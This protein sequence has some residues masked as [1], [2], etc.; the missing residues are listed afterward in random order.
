[1][2]KKKKICPKAG[3]ALKREEIQCSPL[4]VS[5]RSTN[6]CLK[7]DLTQ[8]MPGKDHSNWQAILGH[9]N[10]NRHTSNWSE[11]DCG[12]LVILWVWG[13]VKDTVL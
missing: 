5:G 9:G 10:N 11:G 2:K 12:A 8:H 7:Y 6:M 4:A 1:M 3:N 13:V